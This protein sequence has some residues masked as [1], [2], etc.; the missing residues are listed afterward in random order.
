MR[1]VENRWDF[2]GLNPFYRVR[3]HAA[4]A[5]ESMHFGVEK[6]PW[7]TMWVREGKWGK[8]APCKEGSP[9]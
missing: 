3:K 7:A 9:A 8:I 6:D 4:T 2:F 1:N 5:I